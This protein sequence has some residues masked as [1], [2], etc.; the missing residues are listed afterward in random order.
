MKVAGPG[1]TVKLASWTINPS[2]RVDFGLVA[3][4]DLLAATSRTT[5]PILNGMAERK[6]GLWAGAKAEWKTDLFEARRRMDRPTPP[7]TARARNSR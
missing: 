1:L 3:R 5:P 4:L 6:G 7:A 2:Q